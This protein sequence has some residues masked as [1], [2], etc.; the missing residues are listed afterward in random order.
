MS[1]CPFRSNVD[2]EVE[3]SKDCMLYIKE[4]VDCFDSAAWKDYKTTQS[5]CAITY[6]AIKGN[7]NRNIH[8]TING[9]H[10]TTK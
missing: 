8:R 3:C 5:Y 9:E 2:K 1:F 4:E 6:N 7:N 10:S